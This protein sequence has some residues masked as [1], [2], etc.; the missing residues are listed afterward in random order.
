MLAPPA[1]DCKRFFAVWGG[2]AA[3]RGV[4]ERDGG[5]R[6]AGRGSAG[7]GQAVRGA[8]MRP[9]EEELGGQRVDEWR[10]G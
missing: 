6:K 3:R 5:G 10:G 1:G 8:D 2:Y 7:G 9:A 4:A